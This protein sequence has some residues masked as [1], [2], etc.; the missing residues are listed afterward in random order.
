MEGQNPTRRYKWFRPRQAAR[1]TENAGATNYATVRLYNDS[2]GPV[3]LVVREVV[4]LTGAG[5]LSIAMGQGSIGVAGAFGSIQNLIPG[6]ARI[7]GKLLVNDDAALQVPDYVFSTGAPYAS[8][9]H[10]FPFTVIPPNWHLAMQ[11]RSQGVSCLVGV[12]WEAILADQLDF[13]E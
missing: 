1:G 10:D 7:P 11:N 5:T 9:L 3:I 2:T 4:W 8:W 13:M 6:T 12:M